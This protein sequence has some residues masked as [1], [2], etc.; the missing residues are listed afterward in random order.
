VISVFEGGPFSWPVTSIDYFD[1]AKARGGVLLDIGV[2]VLDLLLW[3]LGEPDRIAYEDDALGGV[4]VNCRVRLGFQSGCEADIQL[5]REWSRP[6]EYLIQ[7]TKGVLRWAA[8][9]SDRIRISV[10]GC[11]FHLNALLETGDYRIGSSKNLPA[12]HFQQSFINQIRNVAAAIRGAEP[13]LISGEEG[14][15]SLQLVEECYRYR[16]LMAMPWLNER[17]EARARALV[18]TN[19]SV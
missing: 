6:N 14:L 9:E 4:E 11:R 13:L 12:P 17:E 18:R 2:H 1:R 16:T 8:N 19:S 5:S 15:R 3:W 7:G 10:G